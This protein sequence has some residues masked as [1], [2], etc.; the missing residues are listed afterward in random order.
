MA[1]ADK[2]IIFTECLISQWKLERYQ[3]KILVAP[4]LFV[5]SETFRPA[6]RL[7]ERGNI[8]GYIGR[9]D[10]EKGI[11]N[12]IQALP[13]LFQTLNDFTALVIGDGLL[14]DEVKQFLEKE[15]LADRVKFTGWVE[16]H[17]MPTYLQ[18]MK[19]LVLPSYT[20]GLPNIVLEAM[21]CGT[22]VL[23][24]SVGSIP[25]IIKDG[26]T[27]FIMEDNSPE[28]IVRNVLK[29][30]NHPK[31]KEISQSARSFIEA[32]YSY[33]A[34]VGRYKTVVNEIV[35]VGYVGNKRDHH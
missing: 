33:E 14:R 15:K 31:M 3:K 35:G 6:N 22:P 4:Y 1:L 5:D 8:L 28:C 20:E 32:Q 9:L 26:E 30:L 17:N 2:I 23:I 24:T 25:D 16:H 12:F 7:V 11:L 13:K 21:A 29:A 27:G 18:Q 34:I 10:P 19:L